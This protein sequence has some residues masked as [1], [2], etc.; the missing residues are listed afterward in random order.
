MIPRQISSVFFGWRLCLDHGDRYGDQRVTLTAA[1]S[2]SK[3][4]RSSNA[5][6]ARHE[7]EQN[8]S[9]RTIG[10]WIVAPQRAQ[11]GA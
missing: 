2:L 10:V 3:L 6:R 11:H 1:I 8:A 9:R 7:R 5:W 4:S